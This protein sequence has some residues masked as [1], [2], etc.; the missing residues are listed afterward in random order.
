MVNYIIIARSSFTANALDAWLDLLGEGSLKG[1]NQLITFSGL[2]TRESF[3][4]AFV[5]L[6]T[7]IEKAVQ[8][9]G[10]TPHHQQVIIIADSVI[11]SR[12]NAA[13]E[14]SSWDNLLAML[15]LGFPELQWVFGVSG[16]VFWKNEHELSSLIRSSTRVP[17]FDPSGLREWV[18]QTTK[19]ELLGID[20]LSLPSRNE[21]AAAIDEERPYAYLHGY[22]AYRF[23]F[24]SDVITTWTAMKRRFACSN[25][26]PEKVWPCRAAEGTH[27]YWLLFEDMSLNFPDKP[28]SVHLLRLAPSFKERGSF[29]PKLNSLNGDAERSEYRILVTTGQSRRGDHAFRENRVHLKQKVF[30]RGGIVLKPASGMFDLWFQAGLLRAPLGSSSGSTQDHLEFLRN[31]GRLRIGNAPGFFW[32]PHPQRSCSVGKLSGKGHGAPGK[33]LLVAELLVERA[34]A[35]RDRVRSVAE[36]VLG[37][38]LATDALELTGGRTPTTAIEALSL[39]H[40]F[41]VLAECQFSGVEYH[42]KIAPRI[43]EIALEID[44]ISLWFGEWQRPSARLNARMHILNQLI[45]ILR[46]NNRFDEEQLC[47]RE[48]RRLHTTLWMKSRPWRYIFWLPIRYVELLLSSFLGFVGVLCIW[49]LILTLMFALAPADSGASGWGISRFILGFENAVTSF[50]SVGAP[51]QQGKPPDDLSGLYVTVSAVAIIS[52]FLHLGVLISHLYTVVSRR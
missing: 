15:I 20:D 43:E 18:R 27:G 41:E 44:A 26:I 9:Y 28:G 7:R 6:A 51:M 46:E 42:I 45:R 4:D 10:E 48:V 50:F 33:L 14:G 29:C 22:T 34:E 39:K 37:A 36:A 24:R 30:G 19:N 52:G 35:L 40:Q 8:V 11:P 32:P 3:P 38:T 12:M 49:V 17:L 25:D 2:L 5:E 47:L 31:G 1:T 16:N 21:M 13:G 23:G